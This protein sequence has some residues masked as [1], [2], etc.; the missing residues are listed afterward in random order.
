M[1]SQFEKFHEIKNIMLHHGK[2]LVLAA[3]V[4]VAGLIVIKW[5]HRLLTQSMDRLSLDSPIYAT[6]RNILCVIMYSSVIIAASVQAGLPAGPVIQ[7]LTIISLVVIGIIVV[8]R[9]FI[10]TLPFKVGNT[11]KAGDLL[12]KIEATTVLNTRMRT[13]DGK[14]V[15]IPNRKILDDIVI[16]YHFTPSRRLKIDVSIGYK[17]DLMKAKQILEAIMIE[18]PRVL[19]KPRPVVYVLELADSSVKLGGRA[20]VDNLKYWQTKC[21]LQEKTKLRFDHEG[22]VFAYP[23][24]DI[25]QDPEI[26]AAA[27]VIEDELT[28]QPEM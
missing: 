17:E 3:I 2:D 22:I 18:D 14:T 28:A 16:N 25:H 15:F 21:E 1:E 23:Q 26:G 10:P 27:P 24:L 11:V 12:G 5:A 19:T 6:V 8:F 13:F 7:F 20:W 9:P 4:L